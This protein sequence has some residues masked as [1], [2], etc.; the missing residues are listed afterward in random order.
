M[1][2]YTADELLTMNCLDIIHSEDRE[3][4]Q[5]FMAQA[6]RGEIDSFVREQRYVRKNGEIFWGRLRATRVRSASGALLHIVA[7]VEDITAQKESE[8]LREAAQLR[9]REALAAEVHHRLKNSLQ[10]VA[11]LLERYMEGNPA[12]RLILKEA[13]TQVNTLAMMHGLHSESA[14]GEVNL[15][16]I[17]RGIVQT[18]KLSSIVPISVELPE[19]FAPV[20]VTEAERVPIALILNEL[21]FN[22][23]KYVDA[24]AEGAAVTIQIVTYATEA[25]VVVRN[26]P[27]HLPEHVDLAKEETLGTG[28]RLVRLLLPRRGATLTLATPSPGMVEAVL[29]LSAPVLDLSPG[30]TPQASNRPL[31][32]GA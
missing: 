24:A 15:C 1:V 27:A 10:G 32:G 13:I 8:S 9:Q 2:G 19:E 22:A 28:L 14:D 6:A 3:A 5:R 4:T 18:L 31:R 25:R 20:Q 21:I 12:C 11:G 26:M 23:L 16:N 7:M 29:H 30:E 17:A